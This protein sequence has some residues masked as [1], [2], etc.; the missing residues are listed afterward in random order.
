MQETTSMPCDETQNASP[1][2]EKQPKKTKAS[3][4]RK[5]FLDAILFFCTFGLY[6]SF[7]LYRRVKEIKLISQ[8]DF[9]PWLWVFVPYFAIVQFFAFRNL[10]KA[11]SDLEGDSTK[12]KAQTIYKCGS[13]GFLLTTL[14]FSGTSKWATPIWLD[15]VVYILT[16]ISF[17]AIAY[18][19]NAYKKQVEEIEFTGKKRG[20]NPLEWVIFLLMTPTVLGIFAFS[21]LSPLMVDKLDSFSDGSVFVQ[22]NHNYKLTFH[23][24]VWQQVEVGTYSD[25]T[26]LA[27]FE[28]EDFDAYFMIFENSDYKATDVNDH[29]HWRRQWLDEQ[30]GNSLCTEN[31]RF[32]G[33]E[34]V[35]KVEMT[36]TENAIN[37]NAAGFIALIHSQD[38][39][40]ELLG[41]LA[42]PELSF[43]RRKHQFEAM[44]REFTLQ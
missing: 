13:Y 34:F 18:R 38:K 9:K 25:G 3:Y 28:S 5:P 16:T 22:E 23:G 27:E 6:T 32:I 7:W 43:N 42:Q 20:F 37:A 31:R 33:D 39:A 8:G 12:P 10:G 36:C 24:E 4:P 2:S 19:V 44:I 30:I 15:F 11:L 40:Y 14:Y 35:V 29:V 41:I 26:A 21:I 1:P 17:G